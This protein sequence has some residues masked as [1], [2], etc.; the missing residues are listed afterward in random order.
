MSESYTENARRTLYFARSEASEFGSPCIES[1][2][3]LLGL[4]RESGALAKLFPNPEVAADMLR[5]HIKEHSPVRER[6]ATSID[7]PISDECRRILTQASEE[8]ERMGHKYIGT[9]HLLLGIL[10]EQGS[11]V[12][13]LLNENGLF[14]DSVREQIKRTDHTFRSSFRS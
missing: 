9:E 3:L 8:A 1:Q 13:R 4:L 2:H 7:L 5:K 14:L 10:R 12:A 11:Y 6:I